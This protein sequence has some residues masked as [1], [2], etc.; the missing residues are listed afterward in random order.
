[1]QAHYAQFRTGHKGLGAARPGRPGMF[2]AV[3]WKPCAVGPH[4]GRDV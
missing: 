3:A 4:H 2:V 1:M